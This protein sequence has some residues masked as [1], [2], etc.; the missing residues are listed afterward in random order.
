MS[1]NTHNKVV[2]TAVVV[3]AAV[4]GAVM[5]AELSGD[6]N[7]GA[8]PQTPAPTIPVYSPMTAKPGGPIAPRPSGYK[9]DAIELLLIPKQSVEYKFRLDKGAVMVYSW[10]AD[11]RIRFDFHTV[12]DGKPIAV[13]VSDALNR[14]AVAR[15]TVPAN[16]VD[17][18]TRLWVRLYPSRFSEIV[19][20]LENLVRLP[21]G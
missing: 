13:N 14:K 19:S 9:V 16:A 4:L 17:G 10:K 20:G 2:L 6:Q 11:G 15:V 3:V 7:R 18:A 12:P 8:G 5:P 21:Y 1:Q